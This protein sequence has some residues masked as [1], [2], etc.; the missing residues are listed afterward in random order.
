MATYKAEA[1]KA[2]HNGDVSQVVYA[3]AVAILG[4]IV[5]FEHPFMEKLGRERIKSDVEQR[6]I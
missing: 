4:E 6:E 3:V 2:L 1:I 5:P